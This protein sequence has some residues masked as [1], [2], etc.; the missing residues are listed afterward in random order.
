LC[1]LG[2]ELHRERQLLIQTRLMLPVILQYIGESALTVRILELKCDGLIYAS[3][4][5][6]GTE[7]ATYYGI[8]T[9]DQKSLMRSRNLRM[10]SASNMQSRMGS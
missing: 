4:R 1:I 10:L 9:V 6:V 3:E 8:S 2:N 5:N 7:L